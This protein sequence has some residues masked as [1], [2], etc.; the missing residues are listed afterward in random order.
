M[1]ILI[2]ALLLAGASFVQAQQVFPDL[3]CE[4]LSDK[5]IVIP[6]DTRGKST[7][8]CLAMSPRAEKLLRGWNNP[9]YNA[10][11]ADGMGGLMGGRMYDANL[12]FV[13]MLKGIAKLGLNETKKQ[14]K[15]EIEK[16]LHDYFMVSDDN[17]TELMKSLQI[18]DVKEP[19]FF[20]LNAD[21]MIIYHTQGEYSAKKLDEITEKLI[22]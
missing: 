17:V 15:K 9:L 5:K 8:I 19:H 2:T 14:S 10:L 4:S 6:A 13:G 20:V 3:K 21:G 16:K 12:C 11:I 1:K 7:V 22:Q 18:K